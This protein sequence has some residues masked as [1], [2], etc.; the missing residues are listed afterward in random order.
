MGPA[1]QAALTERS[2]T[3]HLPRACDKG[4]VFSVSFFKV[5][6]SWPAPSPCPVPY[7]PSPAADVS[8]TSWRLRCGSRTGLGDG[9]RLLT[10]PPFSCVLAGAPSPHPAGKDPPSPGPDL[11][12]RRAQVPLPHT[13]PPAPPTVLGVVSAHPP[14]P[15][16]RPPSEGWGPGRRGPGWNNFL[17]LLG[18]LLPGK[19]A[20]CGGDPSA[21]SPERPVLPAWAA[22]T[23]PQR[24]PG[25]AVLARRALGQG[26]SG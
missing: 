12:S 22:P 24:V 4:P 13:P 25:G 17:G 21:G 2:G 5:D 10:G 23:W 26:H 9:P 14:T 8:V 19:W 11:P 18:N 20:V 1:A 7:V 3:W 16:S 15:A 6:T